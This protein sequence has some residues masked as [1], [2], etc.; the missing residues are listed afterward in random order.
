[1]A[2]TLSSGTGGQTFA[3]T[4][5]PLLLKPGHIQTQANQYLMILM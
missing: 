4:E 1:M 3:V 2:K 5:K